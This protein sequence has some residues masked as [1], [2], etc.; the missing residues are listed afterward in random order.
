M[1]IAWYLVFFTMI[2]FVSG[3]MSMC[4]HLPDILSVPKIIRLTDLFIAGYK[5]EYH[6]NML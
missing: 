5:T 1:P 2:A 3:L 6:C 4:Q